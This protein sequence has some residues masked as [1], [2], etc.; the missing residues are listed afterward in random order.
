MSLFLVLYVVAICACTAAIVYGIVRPE[1]PGPETASVPE[2]A[3]VR[4]LHP[5]PAVPKRARR[6][7]A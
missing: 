7:A 3:S 2:K 6:L 1:R 4:P 5:A